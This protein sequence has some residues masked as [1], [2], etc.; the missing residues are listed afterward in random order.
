MAQIPNALVLLGEPIEIMIGTDPDTADEWTFDEDEFYFATD[1]RGRELWILPKP[2]T[3]RMT[4]TVPK[5]AATMFKRFAG[6]HPDK[7]W[8]CDVSEF[9]PKPF[10]NCLAIAYRSNKWIGRQTGYVHTFDHRMKVEV[11]NKKFP[12]IWRIT[13]AKLRVEARGITG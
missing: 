2:D 12:G 10:G 4:D 3:R 6:W 9:R 7:A 13:G 11:D 1:G 5:G 8:R